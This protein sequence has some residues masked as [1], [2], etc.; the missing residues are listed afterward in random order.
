MAESLVQDRVSQKK[1][2]GMGYLDQYIKECYLNNM[3]NEDC[4]EAEP[5]KGTLWD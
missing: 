4:W 2:P 1:F 5:T 3:M